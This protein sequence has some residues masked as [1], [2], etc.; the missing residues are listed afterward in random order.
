MEKENISNS[1]KDLIPSSKEIRESLSQNDKY[2]K[3]MKKEITEINRRIKESKDIGLSCTF[4]PARAE[5]E[6]DLK[7]LYKD[8]GYTFKPTGYIGGVWQE[9]EEICW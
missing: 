7:R 8:K 9:T 5:Y 1:L 3:E 2:I 6:D 4:F